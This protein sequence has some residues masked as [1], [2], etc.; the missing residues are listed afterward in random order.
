MLEIDA[1]GLSA[2]TSRIASRAGVAEGT[3]FTYFANKDA[4]LNE[5]YLELK[6]ELYQ[7]LN[8]ELDPKAG[9]KVRTRQIWFSFLN[10]AI[11][12][13]QKRKVSLQLHMSNLIA[14][15]TRDQ[16]AAKSGAVAAALSELGECAA[17]R[18]LPA[19]FASSSMGAMQE[20]AMDLIAKQP[21]RREQLEREAFEAFWRAVQ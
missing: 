7:R 5:L 20:V 11:E 18:G 21:E 1:S 14:S 8:A 6:I 19:E 4:L 12:Y 3:L 9:L 2:P 17:K 16:A 13:P 15:N 10:W